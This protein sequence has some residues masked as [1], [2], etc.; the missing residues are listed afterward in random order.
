[1]A[2]G[3]RELCKFGFVVN[4]GIRNFEG[5]RLT[6]NVGL[7]IADARDFSQIAS[8]RGGTATS[9]HIRYFQ[10]DKRHRR[11]VFFCLH[12]GC[13]FARD[14]CVGDRGDFARASDG[15]QQSNLANDRGSFH[16][17]TPGE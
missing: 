8:D 14:G 2:V 13:R 3:F 7:D 4:V 1:M 16:G 9:D 17:L 6:G 11:V 15:S 5:T 10:A 12:N